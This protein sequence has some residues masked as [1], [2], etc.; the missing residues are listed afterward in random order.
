[1]HNLFL[2]LD[3]SPIINVCLPLSSFMVDLEPII[4]STILALPS[5]SLTS[6]SIRLLLIAPSLINT[7]DYIS[8]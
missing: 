6:L 3:F 8:A 5:S 1:M 2:L 4:L 7:L